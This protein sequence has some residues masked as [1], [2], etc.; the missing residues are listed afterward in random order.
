[1]G[2]GGRTRR[3][4][5]SGVA[6]GTRRRGYSGAVRGKQGKLCGKPE[7]TILQKEESLPD[8]GI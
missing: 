1:M 6:Y 5:Y 8:K 7:K 2:G 3:R 4:D